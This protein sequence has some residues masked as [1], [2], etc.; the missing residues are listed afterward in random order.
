MDA[1]VPV[2][3]VPVTV[4]DVWTGGI[5]VESVE[6]PDGGE[7]EES[8]VWAAKPQQQIRKTKNLAGEVTVTI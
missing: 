4:I 5:A 1:G 8:G 3:T 7:L 2:E 6:L